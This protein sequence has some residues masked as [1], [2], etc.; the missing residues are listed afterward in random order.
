MR[1]L[2]SLMLLLATTAGLAWADDAEKI[3]MARVRLST[4]PNVATGCVRVGLVSDDS[5]KDLRRKIV[6]AGGNTG[7]L[8]FPTYDLGII[9]ALVLRCDAP[10]APS[11]APVP[12]DIPPPPLGAPPPPPPGPSR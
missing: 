7:I 11:A 3:A 2:T 1:T 12:P 10:G 5:I 6:R 4:E 8:W 9:N